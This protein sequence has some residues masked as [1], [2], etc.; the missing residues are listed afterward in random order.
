MILERKRQFVSLEPYVTVEPVTTWSGSRVIEKNDDITE[1]TEI[2]ELT[3][4]DDMDNPKFTPISYI[5][6]WIP[7]MIFYVFKW[8]FISCSQILSNNKLVWH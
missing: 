4:L 3:N 8:P 5:A 1:F 6:K 7:R 2:T